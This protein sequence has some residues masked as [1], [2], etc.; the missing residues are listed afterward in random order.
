[1]VFTF[2]IYSLGFGKNFAFAGLL[3][4]IREGGK[5]DRMGQKTLPV[6]SVIKKMLKR[7]DAILSACFYLI[8]N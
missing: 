3:N 8:L 7:S 2:F 6:L 4:T 1:M 5:F